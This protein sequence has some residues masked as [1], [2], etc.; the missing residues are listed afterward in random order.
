MEYTLHVTGGGDAD[1]LRVLKRLIEVLEEESESG[2]EP[3]EMPWSEDAFVE[4]WGGLRGNA[5]K[6]LREISEQPTGYPVSD[7]LS[8]LGITGATLGGH[9]S[10]VGF[11]MRKFPGYDWPVWR[12]WE[13]EVYVMPSEVADAIQKRGL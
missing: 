7:L 4:F 9:L 3:E 13:N 1:D 6:A 5:K 2:A 10:S 11:R 12:D 8:K